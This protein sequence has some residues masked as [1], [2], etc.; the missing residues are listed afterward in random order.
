MFFLPIYLIMKSFL[1]VS[2]TATSAR[3]ELVSVVI[4]LVKLAHLRPLSHC[5][6]ADKKFNIDHKLIGVLCANLHTWLIKRL[7]ENMDVYESHGI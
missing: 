5:H 7:S 1:W 2:H 6:I 3:C 4:Y